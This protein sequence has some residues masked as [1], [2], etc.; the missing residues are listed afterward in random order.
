MERDKALLRLQLVCGW[1]ALTLLPLL[2]G[3]SVIIMINY[4]TVPDSMLIAACAAFAV[5][6]LGLL[7]AAYKTL[8]PQKLKGEQLSPVTAP[9][10]YSDPL[11]LATAGSSIGIAH[12]EQR[13]S[14]TDPFQIDDPEG[15]LAK[16]RDQPKARGEGTDTVEAEDIGTHI[17]D[18]FG[19]N[20]V[21]DVQH[22]GGRGNEG[23]LKSGPSRGARVDT[24]SCMLRSMGSAFADGLG[25][26][27]DPA[28][29]TNV[30]RHVSR[31]SAWE[32]LEQRLAE[33]YARLEGYG[34]PGAS[35]SQGELSQGK[36][37]DRRAGR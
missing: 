5:D 25:S 29:I 3:V 26:I 24:G 6:V 8:V 9:P 15:V 37:D 22:E 35:N 2:A 33:K 32:R 17:D 7:V 13:P 4:R 12:H 34:V 18:N 16:T 30:P 28:G 20:T 10:V 23:V 36:S 27:F 31:P 11:A 21:A 14:S 19:E 1:L